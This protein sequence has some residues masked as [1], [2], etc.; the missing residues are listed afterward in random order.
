MLL[1]Y[2]SSVN[3]SSRRGADLLEEQAYLPRP[4]LFCC[5]FCEL[6]SNSVGF[7]VLNE[8]MRLSCPALLLGKCSWAPSGQ[9]LI[10]S[11]AAV[12]LMFLA[13]IF[14]F[15]IKNMNIHHSVRL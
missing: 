10:I 1:S 4:E 9:L 2:P 15:L 8:L 14:R 5:G 11:S 3:P 6:L 13:L 12:H 7:S